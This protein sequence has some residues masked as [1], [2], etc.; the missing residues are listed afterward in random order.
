MEDEY[1]EGGNETLSEEDG[2]SLRYDVF[3]I[4]VAVLIVFANGTALALAARCEKLRTVTNSVLASLAVSDL[5]AGILG[6][7]L[8]LVCN[9]SYDTPWCLSSVVFWRFVSV[10]TVLHLTILTLQL[11][12]TVVS[13]VAGC[14]AGSLLKG[15]VSAG[16]VCAAWLCAA[17]VSLIQLSWI[18]AEDESEAE[19]QRIHLAYAT[20]V[21][22]LFLGVPLV[23]MIYCHLRV[24]AVVRFYRRERK[25]GEFRTKDVDDQTFEKISA[26]WKSGVLLAGMLAVFLICWA[27]YFVLEL[28]VDTEGLRTLPEWGEY[29]LFYFTR[30]T[31]SAINPILFIIG[32]RDFRGALCGCLG[33][34]GIKSK[35]KRVRGTLNSLV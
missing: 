34:C 2:F 5:L 14:G 35:D 4:V 11:Y 30:F 7:P 33:C 15:N 19:R 8:Y 17:F 21:L 1:L 18:T 22:A 24:Y 10:S 3:P 26:N 16:L 31:A 29:V 20:T 13:Y 12:A 25:A 23:I 9:T 32:K 28:V 6:I 27:P